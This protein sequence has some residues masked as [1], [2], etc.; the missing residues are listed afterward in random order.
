ARLPRRAGHRGP[1][2]AEVRAPLRRH[3]WRVGRGAARLR[4]R[5][6]LP[7]LPQRRRELPPVG[8]GVREPQPVRVRR[9]PLTG[10]PSPGW[11]DRAVTTA[12]STRRRASAV[13]L[14]VTLGLAGCGGAS[15]DG[16][17]TPA[18]PLAVDELA[19]PPGG[20]PG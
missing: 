18:D 8:R 11:Q 13:A 16:A 9:A 20:A 2:G 7:P 1:P 6:P 17:G 12:R 14:A 4:R 10:E 15:G 5:R 19:P 3:R